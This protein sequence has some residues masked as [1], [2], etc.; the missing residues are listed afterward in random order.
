MD[1]T[2]ESLPLSES[3][4]FVAIFPLL[5]A[6]LEWKL[7]VLRGGKYFGLNG[8]TA[9][10]ANTAVLRS[11]IAREACSFMIVLRCKKSVVTA[12]TLFG[13]LIKVDSHHSGWNLRVIVPPCW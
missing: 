5:W 4:S 12:E 1:G 9:A 6:A 10:G 13:N 11:V 7:C 8:D 2:F 3:K